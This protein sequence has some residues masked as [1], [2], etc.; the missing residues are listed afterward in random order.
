MK[1]APT[2]LSQMIQA[3]GGNVIYNSEVPL[4][5]KYY[6]TMK[7]SHTIELEWCLNIYNMKVLK[8]QKCNIYVNMS[9]EM[10]TSLNRMWM[11][12]CGHDVRI[13]AAAAQI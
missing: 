6:V 12:E 1:Q 9:S 11:G 10:I 2:L 4:L 3:A 5:V 13:K 7:C 8:Y